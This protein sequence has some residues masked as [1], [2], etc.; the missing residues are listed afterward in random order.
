MTQA[1]TAGQGLYEVDDTEATD[2]TDA[3]GTDVT[4]V[5][6]QLA[7]TVGGV[8]QEFSI[9]TSTS[10]NRWHTANGLL[11]AVHEDA[12]DWISKAADDAADARA[13][14]GRRRLR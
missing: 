1:I 2:A 12:R 13:A 5:T 4:D 8:R 11:R 6:V 3:T 9:G 7:V 14:T 10:V